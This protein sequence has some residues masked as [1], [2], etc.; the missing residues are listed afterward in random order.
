ME[1]L[2]PVLVL[3]CLAALILPWVNLVRMN[4]VHRELERLR[5]ELN[6]LKSGDCSNEEAQGDSAVAVDIEPVRAKMPPPIVQPKAPEFTTQK[7]F[8]ESL[9]NDE[10][11]PPPLPVHAQVEPNQSTDQADKPQDWFSKVAVWVG[12]VALLM[13]GFYMIKY[14][15]DWGWLTPLVRLWLTAVFGA[16]LCIVGFVIGVRS[17][18]L[19]RLGYL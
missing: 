13:A 19:V 9:R 17:S 7:E 16:M 4:R 15:I 6:E 14:S 10:Q 11:V 1:L 3:L 18:F 5:H 8:A 2:A 12:S